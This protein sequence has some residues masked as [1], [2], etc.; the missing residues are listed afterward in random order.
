MGAVM[1]V[2]LA[3][4]P[5]WID[6]CTGINTNRGFPC[7]PMTL[8]LM[9]GDLMIALGVLTL[10]FGPIVNSMYRLVRYG[11]Q[12]ETSRVETAVGNVPLVI[13]IAYIVVGFVIAAIWT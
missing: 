7:E 11:Q 6:V 10:I 9:T 5:R 8:G 1:V 4:Q 12:W 2:A 13:G 3:T